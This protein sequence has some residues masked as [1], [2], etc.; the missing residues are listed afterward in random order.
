MDQ[1]RHVC[2]VLERARLQLAACQYQL[3]VQLEDLVLRS[4]RRG[5][6]RLELLGLRRDLLWITG[7]VLLLLRG[8]GGW[9]FGSSLI[10]A[11]LACHI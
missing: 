6:H 4:G 7:L 9:H 1:G 11:E 3:L 2:V 8:V 5:R 10:V